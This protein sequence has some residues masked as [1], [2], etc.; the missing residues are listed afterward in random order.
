MR[1]PS[2]WPHFAVSTRQVHLAVLADDRA[3]G[4]DEDRRVV[5]MLVARELGI[6]DIKPNSQL[7]RFGKQG[8]RLRGGYRRF[9]ILAV[10]LRLVLHP[11]AREE[12]GE[13]ELGEDHELRS[14]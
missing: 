13:G 3:V 12:G 14:H 8:L 2:S 1:K 11:P 6:A 9:E 4:A 10:H 7:L 5:A